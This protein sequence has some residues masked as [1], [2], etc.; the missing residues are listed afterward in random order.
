MQRR[1]LAGV[2]GGVYFYNLRAPGIEE[3]RRMILLP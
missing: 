3:S 1:M 2:V